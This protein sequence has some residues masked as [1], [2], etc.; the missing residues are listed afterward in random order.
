MALI[1]VSD[2]AYAIVVTLA[3]LQT[4]ALI[5]HVI[6]LYAMPHLRKHSEERRYQTLR[7]APNQ[8][9]EK[10]II[11]NKK[12]GKEPW[13]IDA[14]SI[15]FKKKLAKGNFGE[16]WLGSWLG[17]PVAIKTVLR[18]MAKDK[19]FIERF[20]LEIKLM[21]NLHHPNI[22]MFLGACITPVS[23][24]C[25]LLEYCVYGSLHDFLY[26]HKESGDPEDH[27]TMHRVI[28]FAIDIARGVN[29]IHQKC[30]IIQRDLK[31]RNVLVDIHFNA[32][33]AD[34]GL[35]RLKTEDDAGMTA[36]G[37]PAWTA[38]EIVKLEQYD[39]KVD[40]YSFGIVMWELFAREEPYKGQGGVQV[41]YMAVEQGLR[42]EVPYACPRVYAQLMTECWEEDPLLRPDFG[43]ILERLFAMTKSVDE[44]VLRDLDSAP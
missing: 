32:K 17:S 35:S 40:V 39:E 14:K 44:A 37:T 36:C 29:Y 34:F 26:S 15:K 6:V 41:A 5:V 25:L 11:R 2:G 4:L 7:V 1:C 43:Q 22:V 20:M 33:V 12:S 21:S 24:M 18:T 30:N 28:R 38:P 27:V 31:A 8:R 10:Q 19:E 13:E 3:G 16:V 42:P 23:K 9:Q